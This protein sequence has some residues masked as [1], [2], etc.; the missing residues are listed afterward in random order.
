VRAADVDRVAVELLD[1][2][3][4][5]FALFI[6]RGLDALG[7]LDRLLDARFRRGSGGYRR[8]G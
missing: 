5:G 8:F 1:E 4:R 7:S 3:A 2:T 6:N